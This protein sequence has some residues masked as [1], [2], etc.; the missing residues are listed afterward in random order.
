MGVDAGDPAF[1]FIAE[2]GNNGGRVNLGLEGNTAYANTSAAQ[3]LQV[4]T[5]APLGKLQES[6]ATTIQ[7]RSVGLSNLQAVT[8]VNVGGPAIPG[9]TTETNWLSGADNTLVTDTTSSAI[10]APGAAAPAAVYQSAQESAAALGARLRQ[11]F[12]VSVG[13]YVVTLNF[14]TYYDSASTNRIFNI[15]INGVLVAKNFS[16]FAAAG[17][18]NDVAVDRSFQVAVTGTKGIAIALV[19]VGADAGAML[20][21]V[22]VDRVTGASA[23]PTAVVQ[24]SPDGGTTW[25]TIATNVA[26]DPWGNGA[27]VWTP[28]FISNGNTAEVR[29]T[30][31]GVSTTSAPFLVTNGGQDYTPSTPR[32]EIAWGR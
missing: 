32:P 19:N 9:L 31:G 10:S 11:Y 4:L 7:F 16:I 24:L 26:I 17:N 3:S 29:V 28:N 25:E 18:Q 14:A 22:E 8:R 20:S 6:V 23:S 12:A 27:V 30:A 15:Y 21:G 5:P 2:P 1:P 13:N